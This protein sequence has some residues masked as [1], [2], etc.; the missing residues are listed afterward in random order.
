MCFVRFIPEY[1]VFL[2]AIFFFFLMPSQ[3]SEVP[4]PGIEPEP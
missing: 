2:D 1:L 4:G 3:H